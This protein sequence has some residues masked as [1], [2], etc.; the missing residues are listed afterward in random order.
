MKRRTIRTVPK[1]TVP[2]S[3]VWSSRRS[4]SPFSDI[5]VLSSLSGLGLFSM[6]RAG[7]G[8][9]R[10]ETDADADADADP[11]ADEGSGVTA[12]TRRTP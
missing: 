2:A 5:A 11:D 9:D 12:A 10:V 8:T 1:I 6:A 7:E 3:T 4:P